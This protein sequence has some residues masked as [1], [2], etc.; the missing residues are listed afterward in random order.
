MNPDEELQVIQALEESEEYEM[1]NRKTAKKRALKE[2]K[3][4]QL[5]VEIYLVE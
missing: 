5:Q 4:K 3:K 1:A 2:K